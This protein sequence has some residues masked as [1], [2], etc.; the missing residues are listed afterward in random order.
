[1][2]KTLCFQCRGPGFDPWLG[3][4]IPFAATK[5]QSSVCVCVCVY[6]YICVFVYV[7][8]CMYVYMCVCVYYISNFL[9]HPGQC[10]I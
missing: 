7:C 3:N 1:M 9:S 2:A 6:V 10:A 8:V 5:I 4:K